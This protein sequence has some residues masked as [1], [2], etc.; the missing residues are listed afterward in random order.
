[1]DG[2]DYIDSSDWHA[3][4]IMLLGHVSHAEFHEASNPTA[5]REGD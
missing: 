3:C 1:M 5:K 4:D 2:R